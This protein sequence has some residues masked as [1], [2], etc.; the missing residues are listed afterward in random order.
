MTR[1]TRVVLLVAGA[2]GIAAAI[3]VARSP[4]PAARTIGVFDVPIGSPRSFRAFA[5]PETA[6]PHDR[7]G[8]EAFVQVEPRNFEAWLRLGRY[9][10]WQNDEPGAAQA[11]QRASELAGSASS[12]RIDSPDPVFVRA[13]AMLAL[14]LTSEARPVFAQAAG[15]YERRMADPEYQKVP[16]AWYSLGWCRQQTGDLKGAHGAWTRAVL[17][18]E[19]TLVPAD[20]T[21]LYN[22]ACFRALAGRHEPALDSLRQSIEAGFSNRDLMA[23]DEDLASLRADPRWEELL[24]RLGVRR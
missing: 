16:F 6:I 1:S 24:S 14:G 13:N 23:H 18:A 3:W 22:L 7:D 4:A 17:E 12:N 5:A 8:L 20:P 11:F 2:C 9:R 10:R 21:S 19:S 15:M